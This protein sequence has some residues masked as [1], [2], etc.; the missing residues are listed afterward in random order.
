MR[1]YLTLLIGIIGGFWA[2][3]QESRSEFL[4]RGIDAYNRGAYT[5]AIESFQE[6]LEEGRTKGDSLILQT[7]YTNLGNTYSVTGKIEEALANYQQAATM[8]EQTKDLVRLAK[9]IK[10]TGALF[11][12]Q[13]EFDKALQHFD[14]AEKI[15]QSINAEDIIADCR[16][17]RAIIFEFKERYDEAILLYKNALSYYEAHQMEERM[18]LTYNNLGI[19]HKQLGD[20]DASYLYYNKTYEIAKRLD[21]KFIMAATLTNMANVQ[22]LKKQYEKALQLNQ[23]AL[24]IALEIDAKGI[25]KDVYANTADLYAAKKDYKNAFLQLQKFTIANDSLINIERSSQLADMREKYETEKKEAENVMLRHEAAIKALEIQEQSLRLERRNLLLLISFS[26]IVLSALAVFLFFKWQKGKNLRAKEEA[27]RISEEQQRLRFAQD[28]HDDLGAGISRLRMI[29]SL[30]LKKAE[31]TAVQADIRSLAFTAG[32]LVSN[33]RDMLWAMNPEHTTIS[34]LISRLREHSASYFEN[35]PITVNFTAPSPIPDIK[36]TAEQNRNIFLIAKESFQNI[37]KHAEAT[38]VDICIEIENTIFTL[39]ISDNGKG[40]SSSSQDGYG[41]LN[42]K[43]R[44]AQVDGIFAITNSSK[45]GVA[46]KLEISLQ[47]A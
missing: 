43:K 38:Q 9:I 46:I 41:L 12:D 45:G 11:T 42:M 28:L 37:I 8:A 36:I 24:E 32:T 34:F 19:V 33:M 26:F 2:F 30:A 29:S 17:N 13:K 4:D 5:I 14:R 39:W 27:I 35:M 31:D 6:A 10:N 22:T 15:A 23:Q 21:D 25:E 16:I 44:A 3:A 1:A 20:L 18:A 40:I 47:A 7:A